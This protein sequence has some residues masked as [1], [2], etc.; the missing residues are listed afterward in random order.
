MLAIDEK[1]SEEARV[2]KCQWSEIRE[3]VSSYILY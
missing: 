2:T 3:G 1:E